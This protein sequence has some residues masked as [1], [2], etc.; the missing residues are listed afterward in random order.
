MNTIGVF[1]GT[2]GKYKYFV[3]SI[4]ASKL[5]QI[6]KTAS[7]LEDYM[8]LDME[9]KFQRDIN[10][11]RIVSEIAPYLKTNKYRFFG[12]LVM[13]LAKKS[14]ST[15]GV[16]F[17][18]IKN[19]VKGMPHLYRSHL[20][21]FGLLHIPSTIDMVPLDGQ[22]RLKA[23]EAVVTGRNPD[24]NSTPSN[25]D[26]SD[27][28]SDEVATD[29]ITILM[30]EHETKMSR[31]VFT[32][33]NKQAKP[34][35]GADKIILDDNDIRAV[36]AVEIANEV[37]GSELVKSST[38]MPKQA[39]EFTTLDAINK[40]TSFV[41][42]EED[43]T[44]K[45]E[46][47]NFQNLP[48]DQKQTAFR[49]LCND[50]FSTFISIERIQECIAN[51]DIEFKDDRVEFRSEDLLGKPAFQH[52]VFEAWSSLKADINLTDSSIK[53]KFESLDTTFAGQVFE[54]IIHQGEKMV[55]ASENKKCLT[56]LLKYLIGGNGALMEGDL[57]GLKKSYR[58]LREVVGLS[59]SLPDP[60]E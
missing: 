15:E 45:N 59:N 35:T 21:D 28:K 19:L 56:R 58:E 49:K 25:V 3:G 48:S 29:D 55:T 44:I 17:E 2:F 32:K 40:G 51:P 16:E 41:I 30:I 1:K 27:L 23:L 33:I 6:S 26:L 12:P 47:T 36:I 43:H 10:Y 14:G 13:T 22:H 50:M 39:N 18:S 34:I 37:F 5:I 8:D 4:N 24:P 60:L 9:E 54:G 42:Q 57:N 46:T 38:A 52:C 11:K 53:Q 7:E 20:D 31:N